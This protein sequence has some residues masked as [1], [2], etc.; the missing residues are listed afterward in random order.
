MPGKKRH[1]D[2]AEALRGQGALN[3]RPQAVTSELFQDSDFFDPRDLIQVKYEMLRDVRVE[4]R[5]ASGAA[6][7]FGFSRPT[8]YQA[9]AAFERSGV[10]GL[11]PRRRGPRGAHKLTPK[12]A[13]FIEQCL[14]QNESLRPGGLATLIMDRFG[15]SI[16]PRTIER[17]LSRRKKN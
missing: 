16:H 3:P 7:T 10:A 11:I 5:S 14:T 12:I 2:K 8:F 17:G 15:V 13:E 9:L 1:P 4:G 6:A